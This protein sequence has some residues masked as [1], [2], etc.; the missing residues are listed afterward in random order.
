M[1]QGMENQRQSG[2]HECGKKNGAQ[3]MALD[4]GDE[5]VT[6]LLEEPCH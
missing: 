6:V 2:D 1:G 3:E 5:E 4:F